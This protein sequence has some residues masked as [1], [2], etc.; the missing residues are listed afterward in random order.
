MSVNATT[1]CLEHLTDYAAFE[2]LA[3]DLMVCVGYRDLEPLGGAQ[4]KGRDALYVDSSHGS[5]AFAYS[6]RKDWLRKLKHDA[7]KI[8]LTCRNVHSLVFV[9]TARIVASHRDKAE[10]F[11]WKEYEWHLHL[12]GLQR[13]RMLIDA[14]HPHLKESHPSIFTVPGTPDNTDPSLNVL[15]AISQ[16]D[17]YKRLAEADME[18]I[19]DATEANQVGVNI[20]CI[21][22]PSAQELAEALLQPTDILHILAHVRPSGD[23]PFQPDVVPP[24]LLREILRDKGVKLVVLMTCNSLNTALALGDADIGAMI[25]TSNPRRAT[26]EIHFV[27]NLYQAL[28]RGDS[29]KKAFAFARDKYVLNMRLAQ[30]TALEAFS[31]GN[32]QRARRYMFLASGHDVYLSCRRDV[33][34]LPRRASNKRIKRTS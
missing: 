12:Y 31:A 8:S 22:G 13:L 3:N 21:R 16:E 1:Y 14:V 7:K 24:V 2:Y 18:A 27:Y 25:S 9:S 26:A 33:T 32:I 4:D 20:R 34:V 5:T 17:C 29:I 28:G 23:L 11:I 30:D 19:W 15:M 6:V 10:D